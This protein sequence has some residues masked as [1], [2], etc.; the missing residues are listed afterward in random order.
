MKKIFL[1]LALLS[2]VASVRAMEKFKKKFPIG[3]VLE[4]WEGADRRVVVGYDILLKRLILKSKSGVCGY[5]N[6]DE[7]EWAMVKEVGASE[8]QPKEAGQSSDVVAPI[9]AAEVA[10]AE[11]EAGVRVGASFN[12]PGLGRVPIAYTF[13]AGENGE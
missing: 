4:R 12:V 13:P 5:F 2:G 11:R 8:E 6:P 9:T 3:T 1:L 10:R 7:G